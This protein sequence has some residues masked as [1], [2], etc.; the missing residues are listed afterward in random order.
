MAL[1]RIT[2]PHAH[3][4]MRT[5]T[6]MQNVLLAT[7]PGVIVLTHFFGFGTIVN[8]LV[9]SVLALAFEAMALKLRGR[10]LGFYLND[11]SA[12]VTATLLGIVQGRIQQLQIVVCGDVFRIE[13]QRLLEPL[14]RFLEKL[15]ANGIVSGA[16]EHSRTFVQRLSQ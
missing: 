3:G 10:P 7:I 12:L 9:A 5:A 16:A 1:M 2:S 4:P 6:V 13:S 15:P 14:H 11:Y 8:I